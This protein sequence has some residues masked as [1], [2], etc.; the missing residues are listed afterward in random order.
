MSIKNVINFAEQHTEISEK[1]K[2]IIFH[3]R[4]SLHFNGQHVWIKK[5]EGLFDVTMEAFD[6]VE[7]C[8]AVGC[9]FLHQLSKNCNKKYI[10]LYRDNGLTVFKNVSSSKAEKIEKDIQKLFKDNHLNCT[11]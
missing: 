8:E 2:A 9:F 7:V 10:G 1:D 11:M 5:K 4:K 3:A 6:G